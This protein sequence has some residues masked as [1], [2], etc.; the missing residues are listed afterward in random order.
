[1]V[2]EGS[3][4]DEKFRSSSMSLGPKGQALRRASAESKSDVLFSR[5]SLQAAAAQNERRCAIGTA[6]V[7]ALRESSDEQRRAKEE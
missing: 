2:P 1:M 4:D 3:R 6:S 5:A 7:T